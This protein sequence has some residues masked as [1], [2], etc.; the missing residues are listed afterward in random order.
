MLYDANYWIALIFILTVMPTLG[1]STAVDNCQ[2]IQPFFGRI[3]CEVINPSASNSYTRS[4]DV[5]WVKR[6]GTLWNAYTIFDKCGNDENTRGCTYSFRAIPQ[7]GSVVDVGMNRLLFR[8]CK[9]ASESTCD[10]WIEKLR[11]LQPN[12]K[13]QLSGI[14]DFKSDVN[15]WIQVWVDVNAFTNPDNVYPELISDFEA[16]GLNAYD[17]GAKSFLI[18]R[19]CNINDMPAQKSAACM[20]SLTAAASQVM[21]TF[22]TSGKTQIENAACQATLGKTD[23][24]N[25]IRATQR[26]LFDDHYNYVSSYV[27]IPKDLNRKII[28]LNNGQ[29]VFLQASGIGINSYKIEKIIVQSGTCYSVPTSIIPNNGQFACVPGMITA[30]AECVFENDR[31]FFKPLILGECTNNEECINKLGQRYICAN[32]GTKDAKCQFVSQCIFGDIQCPGGGAFITDTSK[33]SVRQVSRWA[34]E[35]GRCLIKET[36]QVQCT[37]PA[38]GCS[39]GVC[40]PETYTCV[41]Q[42]GPDPGKFTEITDFL[43]IAE[44]FI[45][46]FIISLIIVGL[47]TIAGSFFI[48]QLSIINPLAGNIVPFFAVTLVIAILLFAGFG[49]IETKTITA[50]IFGDLGIKWVK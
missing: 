32:A 43:A 19:S 20:N 41:E 42:V 45:G 10:A 49:G 24:G 11:F 12:E 23:L 17:S 13:V 50:S 5:H 38:N 2:F 4:T 35:S 3:E 8:R 26:L 46:A 36:M 37:P 30:N 9:S 29:N 22:D 33:P 40:D 31:T 44:N 16:Y 27:P 28:T 18:V 14:K 39:S 48:P 7:V 15:E 34:C 47:I 25:D 6:S 1:S 21:G